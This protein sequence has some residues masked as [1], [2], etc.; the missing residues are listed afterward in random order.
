MRSLYCLKYAYLMVFRP[1]NNGYFASYKINY[2][3]NTDNYE[4][5]QAGQQFPYIRCFIYRVIFRNTS[6]LFF[7]SFSEKFIN[8]DDI[9]HYFI[10]LSSTFLLYCCCYLKC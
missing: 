9:W 1:K 5:K 8:L 4:L 6:N 10:Y 7:S 3:E 2:P